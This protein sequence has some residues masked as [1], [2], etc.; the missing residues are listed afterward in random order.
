MTGVQTYLSAVEH[1]LDCPRKQKKLL[2]Q[3]FSD[4]TLSELDGSYEE[5]CMQFG[6]PDAVADELMECVD[7]EVLH[8]ST[9][10]KKIFIGAIIAVLA[11]ACISLGYYFLR[12]SPY[13]EID[14]KFTVIT[15][16][17]KA[18]PNDSVDFP[19]PDLPGV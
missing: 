18:I 1:A 9:R 8:K 3:Q 17:P 12:A 14:G 4:S 11:L 7:P 19:E 2:V 10:N 5:L 15:T 13:V 16:E 6:Q